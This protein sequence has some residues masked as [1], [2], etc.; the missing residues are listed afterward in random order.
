MVRIWSACVAAVVVAALAAEGIV[1]L[2]MHPS[3]D[4][5]SAF[6]PGPYCERPD[7]G[8]TFNCPDA[9]SV[10]HVIPKSKI[11]IP[12]QLN[13]NG[14]RGPFRSPPSKDSGESNRIVLVGGQS[15]SF[16]A[17][18]PDRD[19][20]AAVAARSAC[21]PVEISLA[22]FPG[23]TDAQS[24]RIYSHSAEAV[25]KPRHIV[26]QIFANTNP[27]WRQE[28]DPDNKIQSGPYYT[29][30]YGWIRP[31]PWWITPL[32][33][34]HLAVWFA[35]RVEQI[36]DKIFR[37]KLPP[38]SRNSEWTLEFIRYMS[39][40]A[41]KLGADFSVVFLPGARS[42]Y[43]VDVDMLKRSVVNV[44]FVDL[45][46][47]ATALSL[48]PSQTIPDG[49]YNSRLAA[50]LGSKIGSE[51]CNRARAANDYTIS[52]SCPASEPGCAR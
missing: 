4:Y 15:Q 21:T 34:S 23:M 24:W 18:L 20:Y 47:E 38:I 41:T 7:Q 52:H 51:I 10:M 17:F 37:G 12:Y 26:L 36:L 44:N 31:V 14:F 13:E 19:T 25:P 28:L 9:A 46:G 22:A 32:S 8:F 49:H 16:G 50:F 30:M 1:R 3:L 48:Y 11:Y 2:A 42:M 27:T 45:D 39:N 33:G 35:T 6:S 40:E 5:A 43:Y 29:L